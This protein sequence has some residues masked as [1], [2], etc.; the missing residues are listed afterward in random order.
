MA[1]ASY[2][3]RRTGAADALGVVGEAAFV[4]KY[5]GAVL[6]EVETYDYPVAAK[7]TGPLDGIA[8]GLQPYAGRAF[9]D[10]LEVA[11]EGVAGTASPVLALDGAV[12]PGDA[13]KLLG[14]EVSGG[15]FKSVLT[16]INLAQAS[17]PDGT[18]ATVRRVLAYLGIA[19]GRYTLSG[20]AVIFHTLVR[21]E[22]SG[23]EFPVRAIVLGGT[24]GQSVALHYRR[25]GL[26]GYYLLAM[27]PGAS[28]ARSPPSFPPTR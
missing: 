26:G 4:A 10:L 5:F 11:S 27:T 20:K 3:S 9:I 1:A 28:R 25:H 6:Q 22:Q 18:I 14:V 19:G 17:S 23:H 2:G 7:G 8:F 15:A 21:L 24:S 13:G 16:S 12:K